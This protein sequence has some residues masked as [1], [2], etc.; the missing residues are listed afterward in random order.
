MRESLAAH[1]ALV[2]FGL[3]ATSV[4][5]AAGAVVPW[6]SKNHFYPMFR[7][8][9]DSLARGEAPLWNP[10]HFGGHPSVAD[11]QSLL[12]TPTMAAFAALAPG[13][14]M[15]AFDAAILAH[16]VAG[17]FGVLA[18]FRRRG[19]A[20]EGAVL[21]GLV[22]I[23][24]GSAS[25]RLQHTG[26]VISYAML[27]IALAAL[28]AMLEEKSYARA[29]GFGLAGALLA[30]GRDQ[31]AFLGCLTLILA[32]IWRAAE[33]DAP[34][35]WLR[36]RAGV[37]ALAGAIGAALLIVPSLL[38]LQLLAASNRP[39][40]AYGVAATGSLAWVNFATLFAPNVFGSLNW[41][42]SYFGPGYETSVEPDWTDRNVNYLFAGLAPAALFVWH[43]IAGRRL[44]A[45]E[46]RFF[47]LLAGLSAIYALGRATPLFELAFDRL[48]GVSLYRR[49]ADATFLLNF[50][51]AMG[52]GYALHRWLADGAPRLAWRGPRALAPAATLAA[53]LAIGAGALAFAAGQGRLTVAGLA[54]LA[55]ALA[56]PVL[57]LLMARVA[58]PQRARLAA[59]VLVALTAGE[60]VWRNAASSL[61]AEPAARY[62]IYAAP[63]PTERAALA[64]LDADIAA[65]GRVGARPRVEIVGLS[66][67]WMN[68][69]MTLGLEDTLGYNPL[70]LADYQRAV[71]PGE[72]AGDLNLRRFPDTFR[73]W[74]CRLAGLLGL[75]YLVLDRPIADLPRHVPRPRSAVAIFSGERLHVYRLGAAAP[76][77]AL[78]GRV[79]PVDGAAALERGVVPEFDRAR[80]ALVEAADHAGLSPA[81]RAGVGGEGPAGT[82]FIAAYA[83]DRV[84]VD[85]D[86]AAGGL[87]VLHDL[88]YPGWIARVDGVERPLARADLLFRGVE[89][90]PGRHRVEFIFRPFS[91]AN[92]ASAAR[93]ATGRH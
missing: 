56:G 42:Y 55:P 20:V 4:W 84:A 25:A 91:L 83:N 13:A 15:Q 17:G 77:V 80:E 73:G 12:F 63:T 81:L 51:L 27:P 40:I 6:D 5:L 92:L 47:A 86:S 10:Y 18:L 39:G 76:R 71:G 38:T 36:E 26:M 69:S 88:H 31:T 46:A 54:L 93:S 37:I 34:W 43:G 68:A 60:L 87:L 90:G 89:V 45:R 50:A 75:E 70:R 3:A 22:F 53:L 48:P 14:S 24:G 29:V 8:L 19:W 65:R 49:P 72:N 64:A 78:V 61:N 1:A 74:R 59:L 52:A 16:L 33:A 9:A 23:L 7:F 11:P 2:L 62:S 66:G 41:D 58:T 21:A 85:V 57:L 67:P 35:R 82:A 30:L 28:E 79:R 44:F 32:L